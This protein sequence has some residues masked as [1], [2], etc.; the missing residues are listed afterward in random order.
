MSKPQPI[1][2]KPV[3]GVRDYFPEDLRL[4]HWLFGL[5]RDVAERF[6][7]EEYD[8]CVL[9][10]EA[11]YIRKAGD[12]IS[13]QLYNFDDKGGRR[14]A[15]RPEMTPSLARMV[16]SRARTT[17][18]PLRWWSTPQCFR[19]ERMQRGRGREHYQWNMD[20]IGQ[21]SVAAEAELMA[22]QAEFLRRAGL[23]CTVEDPSVEF[24]VSSRKVLESFLKESGVTDEG[25]AAICVIVDKRDKIGAEAT[26][27]LLSEAGLSQ[28]L[29]QRILDLLE[30][31]DLSGL[32][33]M[34]GADN[35][36]VADLEQLLGFAESFGIAHLLRID[37]SIVRG[38]SYYTGIVW[39]LFD[40]GGTVPRAIAGGGRYDNLMQHLGGTDLPMVGFGFGDMVILL[41]LEERGLIPTLS[42]DLQDI[43]YP[44][45]EALFPTAQAI[46][47]TLRSQE[48]NVVIDY[49]LR[50]F[51]NVV[52]AAEEDGAERLW[53]LGENEAAAGIVKV[54]KLDGS[55]EEETLKL[56][57]LIS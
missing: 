56:S 9:E 3:K 34:V 17:R 39:E 22:A 53:I 24:R 44:M 47:T 51:K 41:V 10:T 28:E 14:L 2:T 43:V 7:F 32:K 20:I 11:L 12:D 21:E 49:S 27:K 33:E 5:W 15:L 13:E 54:R 25:F 6:G 29:G 40:V 18:F 16:M 45:S 52:K 26:A 1:S 30:L 50:R 31:R 8:C 46:A 36:G 57:S 48:R 4:R 42:R 35:P 19:Y 55:R 38:L 23:P 37:L